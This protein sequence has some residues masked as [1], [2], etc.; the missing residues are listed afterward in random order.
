MSIQFKGLHLQKDKYTDGSK[1][2]VYVVDE[3]GRKNGPYE[4]YLPQGTLFIK[5]TYKN[6]ELN[7]LYEQYFANN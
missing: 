2:A 7:G 4:Q 6:D 1:A 5:T 3:D